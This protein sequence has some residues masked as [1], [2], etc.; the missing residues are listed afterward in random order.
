MRTIIK[1]DEL[2]HQTTKLD[3]MFYGSVVNNSK[4]IQE[5]LARRVDKIT[6]ADIFQALYQWEPHLKDS[7]PDTALSSWLDKTIKT[8]S[9]K[10]LRATTVGDRNLAAGAS[11][12][13]FRELMRSK[14]SIFKAVLQTRHS[15]DQLEAM[16]L[17]ETTLSNLEAKISEAQQKLA[18]MIDGDSTTAENPQSPDKMGGLSPDSSA[19]TTAISQTNATMTMAS[20]LAAFDAATGGGST[21]SNDGSD[22]VLDTLDSGL[23]EKITAQD[24]LRKVFQI[25]GRM[26]VI[27]QQAKSRKPQRAPTPVSIT[28]GS[29]LSNVISSELGTLSDVVTED[30]FYAKYLD[31]SLLMYDHKSKVNEGLG[32]FICLMDVSGSMGGVPLQT[33]QALYVALSRMA[34]EKQRKVCFIPF[35]SNPGKSQEISNSKELVG[36]ITSNYRGVGSG[37]NFKSALE[38]GLDYLA[39][40]A[41]F[42]LADIILITDGDAYLDDRWIT[43]F[44]EQK[45]KYGFRLVGLNVGSG[46]RHW[47]ESQLKMF[48]ATAYMER[49]QLSKLDWMHNLA[50]SLV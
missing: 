4:N 8:Q 47:Q 46:R 1:P 25:A 10:E 31:K 40:Q 48:D 26:R 21:L 2:V 38:Q 35:A 27:L 45:L 34:V 24:T 42:K 15:K 9:F 33:A 17:D 11:I 23:M 12:T 16:P 13:L 43:W 5:V 29:D 19:I 30:K 32:P 20:E 3:T 36:S 50:D 39:T 41:K 49:G 22:K 37:T 28:V 6:G 44:T 18:D 14:E 7:S